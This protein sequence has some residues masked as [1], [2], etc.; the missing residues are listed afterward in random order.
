MTGY[1]TNFKLGRYIHR[2]HANKSPLKCGRIGSVGEFRDSQILEVHPI[3]SG[4]C[5]ATNFSVGRY[6]HRVHANKSPLK[7]WEYRERGRILGLPKFLKYSLLSQIWRVY[8]QSPSEQKP[9][10]ILG[11]NGAWAYP[12]TVQIFW[13]P[14]IISGMG[15]A[16]NFKFGRYIHRVHPNKSRLKFWE[17]MERGRIQGL[18]KFFEYPLLS[19]ERIKLRTSNLAGVFTVS[20]RIG[21]VGESRDCP[22]FLSTPYYL[23]NG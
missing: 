22:N 10:K 2:V 8:S 9:F 6:I 14:P 23:R 12:G 5:K 19:Q 17:K 1:A 18:P 15:K 13:V 11:E 7:I 4:T 16:T 21:S 3:I 20:R